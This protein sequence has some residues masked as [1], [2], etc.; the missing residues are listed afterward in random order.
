MN[1]YESP[2]IIISIILAILV[3]HFYEENKAL[4]KTNKI[5]QEINI[6]EYNYPNTPKSYEFVKKIG[7]IFIIGDLDTQ[8]YEIN[9]VIHDNY[10]EKTV[11]AWNNVNI[12]KKSEI[13]NNI[14]E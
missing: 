7:S 12:H 6:D 8:E 5:I 11:K 9:F 1:L 10:Y 3:Y 2:L 14:N 4:R 13:N